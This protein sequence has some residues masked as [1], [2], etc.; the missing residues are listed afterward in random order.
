MVVLLQ[1]KS[2]QK[3]NDMSLYLYYDSKKGLVKEENYVCGSHIEEHDEKGK[4][5]PLH[6]QTLVIPNLN[7]KIVVRTNLHYGSKSYMNATIT[8]MDKNVLNFL[9]ISLRHPIKQ[10]YSDP[11]NWDML[12]DGIIALYNSIFNSEKP[13]NTYFDEIVNGIKGTDGCTVD[14]MVDISTRLAEIADSLSGSIY[15][16]NPTVKARMRRTCGLMIRHISQNWDKKW[17]TAG[18]HNTIEANLHSILKYLSEQ[19]EVL[20]ALTKQEPL[21]V[22]K[23]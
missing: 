22:V 6:E 7:I 4:L 17:I 11:G 19:N 8:M 13:I 9:D 16:D 1:L 20:Y 18:R 23:G 5:V 21:V 14:K 15:Y 2:T 12:F 10:V 3:T